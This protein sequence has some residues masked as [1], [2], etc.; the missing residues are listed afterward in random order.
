MRGEMGDRRYQGDEKAKHILWHTTMCHVGG[1]VEDLLKRD[2][3]IT[4]AARFR[5]R[6]CPN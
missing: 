6:R 4:V 3:T 5:I 2:H 1:A